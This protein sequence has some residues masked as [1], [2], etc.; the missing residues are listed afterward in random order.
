MLAGEGASTWIIA[1]AL[2]DA[3]L[4]VCLLV[5]KREPI[6]TFVRRRFRKFGLVESAGQLLFI[7]WSKFAQRS[8]TCR[9]RRSDI[10][11]ATGLS[12]TPLADGVHRIANANDKATIN[13]LRQLE[14]SVVVV[15]GTRILSRRLLASVECP[16]INT[17]MGITPAYRGV[18]GGYWALVSCDEENFGATVHLVDPGI[19]TGAVVA[20][21]RIRPTSADNFFT[22][23]ALQLAATVPTLVDTVRRVLHGTIK[24]HERAGPSRQWY[25][26]TIWGYLWRGIVDGVW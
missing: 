1:N 6:T 11:A 25:H 7:A 13:L 21:V 5:E 18:H 19:D 15:N 9:K 12:E 26:P 16:F 10:L 3:G 8:R 2:R 23:P 17:H 4:N 24:T 14:P 20:Q 22:Y